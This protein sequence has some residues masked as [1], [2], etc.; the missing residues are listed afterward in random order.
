[1]LIRLSKRTQWIV[2][3]RHDGSWTVKAIE[4]RIFITRCS[5]LDGC[6]TT[7]WNRINRLWIEWVKNNNDYQFTNIFTLHLLHSRI[8]FI[9]WFTGTWES[10]V[11]HQC[12]RAS[13]S[14]DL[15]ERVSLVYESELS[16]KFVGASFDRYQDSK[17]HYKFNYVEL[18]RRT[19]GR[20]NW[21]VVSVW[22]YQWRRGEGYV[23]LRYNIQWM[24]CGLQFH[25]SESTMACKD[26]SWKWL[27]SI[28][29]W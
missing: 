8:R 25:R 21:P 20:T 6:R 18:D 11:L 26:A 1:M 13:C 7:R 5:N 3:P 22:S 14:C 19:D 29:K 17:V 15:R 28:I 23:S 2:M 10:G 4:M 16:L 27:Q 24:G 9:S 12:A